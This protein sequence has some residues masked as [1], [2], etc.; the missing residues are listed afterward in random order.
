MPPGMKRALFALFFASS[1]LA[2]EKKPLSPDALLAETIGHPGAYNQM[3]DAP[4]PLNP[5]IP[6]PLYHNLLDREV[7]LSE[8]KLKTL[9]ARRAD[10]VP[11]LRKLLASIE[12]GKPAPKVRPMKL[13]VLPEG[14]ISDDVEFS[15]IS[16]RQISG[17]TFEIVRGLKAT[18]ALPEL[19]A[20]EERLRAAL[21]KAANDPKTEPPSVARDG[22]VVFPQGTAKLSK[23]DEKMALGRVAQRELLSLML[24]LLRQERFQPLLD[25]EF[26]QTYAKA[27]KD[28]AAEDDLKGIKTPADAKAKGEEGIEFDPIHNV[29]LGRLRQPPT[30]PFNRDLREKAR[31]LVEKYIESA[32]KKDEAKVVK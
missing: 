19:L 9:Q 7:N 15:G 2:A 25:S 29:P 23:R 32:P 12:P 5:A 13:K 3:C 18:E 27:I 4:D 14:D 6:L 8:E 22:S 1:A 20:L 11:A 30:L 21:E 26:E 17:L 16:P 28:R 24:E 10:V 31:G